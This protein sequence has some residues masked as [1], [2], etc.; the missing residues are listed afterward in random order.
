[1]TW[2]QALAFSNDIIFNGTWC[3]NVP[4]YE[5]ADV[6]TIYGS[7]GTISFGVF[8]HTVSIMMGGKLNHC[9]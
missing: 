3:F 4:E 1:M 6:C 5:A 9:V 8:G 7:K 2:L